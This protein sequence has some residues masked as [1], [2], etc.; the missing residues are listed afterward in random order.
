MKI[1]QLNNEVTLVY[2]QYN[3]LIISEKTEYIYNA[4]KAFIKRIEE[5]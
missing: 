3:E 1:K 5:E 2:N 4:C